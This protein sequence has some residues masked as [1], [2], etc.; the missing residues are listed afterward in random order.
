MSDQMRKLMGEYPQ[1]RLNDNDAGAIALTIREEGGKVVIEFPKSVAW[2]GFTGDQAIEIA[3][4]LIKH[5]R[6]AGVTAPL[7][8]R[9]GE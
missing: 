1:G 9:V 3:K 6:K 7:V 2:I 4:T 8:L 5:A